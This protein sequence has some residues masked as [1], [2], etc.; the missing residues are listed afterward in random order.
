MTGTW[1]RKLRD[2][3][4]CLALL[5]LLP[6]GVHLV[7]WLTDSVSQDASPLL[8]MP[9]WGNYASSDETPG[10][11]LSAW[12]LRT[13]WPAYQFISNNRS[14]PSALQWNPTVALGQPFLANIQNRC[15]SPFSVWFY[16]FDFGLAMF[17][18]LLSKSIVA[19]WIAF[20][21]AR[22][23]GF[24]PWYALIAAFIFQSSG[25]LFIWGM[26]PLSDS[27]VWLPLLL[28]AT[29]RLI[30]GQFRAW[31]GVAFIVGLMVFSGGLS[32]VAVSVSVMAL[33][34][35][36]RR[37]RD[38]KRAHLKGA[39]PGYLLGVVAGL[40]LAAV[41]LLPYAE[42][43]RE[44]N[45]VDHSYP[46]A[47]DNSLLLGLFGPSYYHAITGGDNPLVHVFFVGVVPLLSLGIWITLRR[48][49][50]KPIRHRIESLFFA[51]VFVAAVPVIFRELLPEIHGLRLIH[52]VYYL[53]GLSFPLALLVASIVETWL[54]LNAD[55]CKRA[56][57]RMAM[58]LPFY[59]GGLL[60]V[61]IYFSRDEAGSITIHWPTFGMF[62][63]VSLALALLFGGTLLYPK[64]R[65]LITGMLLLLVLNIVWSTGSW[66]PRSPKTDIFPQTDVVRVLQEADA[67][68]GG[69]ARMAAWP[70]LGNQ[71]PTLYSPSTVE[72][73][74]TRRFLDQ[75]D[76]NPL[77]QRRA[78]VG[79]LLLQKED[80]QGEYAPVR[81]DLNIV[82]VFD[83][84]LVLFRDNGALPRL[85]MVHEVETSVEE[86][87]RLQLGSL[88]VVPG[89]VLPPLTGSTEDS[90]RITDVPRND[91]LDLEV[92]TGHP[93][94]LIVAEAW[95][96]GW[97]ARVDNVPVPIL[98]V[99]GALRGVELGAG[100]HRV[101]FRYESASL[102]WGGI[103]SLV[104]LVVFL[105]GFYRAARRP[106][107]RF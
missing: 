87:S 21:V 56:L 95:Y 58:L 100:T 18:S 37:L 38:H 59:W 94:V 51:T 11:P 16:L 57:A 29:D 8:E 31:P 55:Q 43:L 74:G 60:A 91:A 2:N 101:S 82:D 68:V 104:F 4:L 42:L 30:L 98:K 93:G 96:P 61:F 67:R 24:T 78:A 70:L 45:A 10:S 76:A 80:I 46:W 83:S 33:Y 49:V 35:V 15:F 72:L 17:L 3:G 39:L 53:A 90:I 89:A 85:R 19:G 107:S 102:R 88:P 50:D 75:V 1:G 7:P 54:H 62:T 32:L 26:E 41:Q 28:L 40:G 27:L 71:I 9:I 52:P 86:A 81:A 105:L 48:L 63:L 106:K 69:T 22:R 99:D 12:Q 79:T 44:G 14:T 97:Q 77:L 34:M 47:F 103:I 5:L 65:I 25:P 92:K 73:N 13:S 23:Y 20:Y 84:G 36:F 66:Y 6:L 64:P